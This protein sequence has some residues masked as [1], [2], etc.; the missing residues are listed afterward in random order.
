M[1]LLERGPFLHTLAEYADEARRGDGRLVLV[2]GESGIGKTALLEACRDELRDARW[3][4]GACDGLLTPRPLGPVFDVAAH[5]DGELADLC[6]DGAHR[7]RLFAAFLAEI[8]KP[9]TF[10]VAV[11]EDA[12]WA[13]E[14]TIDLLSFVGRR[15]GRMRALVLVTYRED[16]LGA[17]HPLRIVLGDLATQRATRR[18]RIPPLSVEA[19]RE[20]AGSHMDAAELHRVTGG[21]AFYVREVLEAGWPSIPATVR[22]VVGA[23]LARSSA[24]AR[25]AVEAA[26]VIGARVDPRLLASVVGG[27]QS[28]VEECLA[29][30]ILISDGAGLRFRHELVRMAVAAGVSPHRKAELHASLLAELELDAGYA[31]DA[32]LLAHH[33]EAAGEAKAV[34]RYA[35]E[36]ARRSSDLGAH[37][38]SAAQYERALRF[39]HD[40]APAECALLHERLSGEY[41]LLDRWDEAKAALEAALAIRRDLGD[42]VKVGADLRLLSITLWRLCRGAESQIAA[43][44][45]VRVLETQPAGPDLAWAYAAL[46][47][48]RMVVGQ[49]SDGLRYVDLA[50]ELGER[51][52]Q[53]DVQSYALNASGLCLVE[54]GQD[55]TPQLQRALAIGLE[56]D[57]QEA[58]GRAYS[59]L[60]EAAIHLHRFADAERYYTEGMAYCDGR[61]LG[62]YS[63]CLTG[64][65][66]QALHLL[67][68]FDE[69]CDL[70]GGMLKQHSISPV[71][72]QNPLR[73][74]GSVRGRRGEPG[75][76]ELLDEALPSALG[77][78]EPA[79]I[80]PIRALRTE[81]RWVL[82]EPER[83]AQELLAGYDLLFGQVDPYTTWWLAIWLRRLGL[84]NELPPDAPG[85]YAH[86][87][88]GDWQ[89]AAAAWELLSRPYDAALVRLIGGD[90][91]GLRSALTALDELGATATAAA[92]RRRMRDLGLPA[93]P[94]GPRPATRSAPAGLTA[95]E[96]EVLALLSAGLADKEISRQLFISERT[97]HHHVSAVLAKIGATSRSAAAAQAARLGIGLP[98]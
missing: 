75:A 68:R 46:G 5:L 24:D 38:E 88:A 40:L 45:A 78:A 81:L 11:V 96:Q 2:S 18:M 77:T 84:P 31:A 29:T 12:H 61:E 82:G 94:R 47:V 7:D 16:E 27:P 98:L 28:S 92:A 25:R 19:V 72:R 50:R 32:A 70:G 1:Q 66:A 20:L 56:A 95:R 17:D 65:R 6:R 67:G 58:V 69:A 64:W 57:L 9:D 36:A 4:W 43:Q 44:E 52:D 74:L 87:L 59:S 91:A 90:E 30:G 63:L 54:A 80:V 89:G 55:G 85:P 41:A 22:D 93:I 60:Q 97:V 76:W 21:N 49:R 79:W 14:A 71:N 51:L 42:L 15:L 8:D 10:T 23:R 35:P 39:A 37:R 48:A 86:E 62:V 26:A 13:D 73:V 53:P 33:A 34:L 83:A 3:L